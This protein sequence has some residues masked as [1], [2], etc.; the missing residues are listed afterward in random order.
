MPRHTHTPPSYRIRFVE[1]PDATFEESNGE[2]RPLTAAEYAGNEYLRDGQPIPYDEYLAYYGNPDRHCYLMTEIETT[3]GCCKRPARVIGTGH[4]DFMDDSPELAHVGT[5]YTPEQVERLPEFL[6]TMAF[7][8]LAEAGWKVPR[9]LYCAKRGCRY[10]HV[11][12]SKHCA[13]HAEVR[14]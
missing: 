11:A 5:W 9:S 4:I 12:G 7:E 13:E 2:P 3:C 14:P 1:D 6:Q 8:D 10:W